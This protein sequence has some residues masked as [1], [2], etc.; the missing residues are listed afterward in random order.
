MS[1]LIWEL[2]FDV[3]TYEDSSNITYEHSSNITYEHIT[4]ADTG[5]PV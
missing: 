2:R 5:L 3:K 4:I 1:F